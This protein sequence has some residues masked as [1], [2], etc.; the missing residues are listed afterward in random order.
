MSKFIAFSGI[1]PSGNLTIGNYIG[2]IRQWLNMQNNYNCI[3]CVADLHAITSHYNPLL[4]RQFTLDTIALYLACGI[5]PNKSILFVQ[6]HVPEH[7]Q[8]YWLLNCYTLCSELKNMTQFKTKSKIHYNNINSGLFNYPVLMAADILLYQSTYVP[9]G[10]DQKQHLELSRSI[11]K[12][13]NKLYGDIFT[14]PEPYILKSYSRVMSLLDPQKKMSKSDT[15]QNNI[16]GLLES[17]D[18]VIKKIKNAITDSDHPPIIKYD[19]KNKPGIS[20]LLNILSGIEGHSIKLLEKK[21]QGMMYA[22]FKDIV[23]ESVSTML[24]NIQKQYFFYRQD[25]KFLEKII[26]EGC[27]KARLQAQKTLKK[28]YNVVGLM[29]NKN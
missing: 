27:C 5:D 24:S 13:F 1:Q 17:S 21:F 15:N 2:A 6:S 3:Y 29:P 20:N 19:I 22:H 9:V 10:Y 25:E 14:I 7:N 4:L 23:A 11:A 18:N 28:V 8:L 12:R 16:I 26:Y